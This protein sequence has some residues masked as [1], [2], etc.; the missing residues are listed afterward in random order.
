MHRLWEIMVRPLIYAIKPKHIVE[1]GSEYGHN[2]K[3]L[4]KYCDENDAKLTSID[5]KPLFDVEELKG[6]YESRFE[7]LEGLS[8]DVLPSI[9][10]YDMVLLDGDH[11]WFTVYHELKL[12]ET[13]FEDGE[14][15]LIVFH[16]ISWPYGRRDLYY[17]PDTIPKEYLNPYAQRGICPGK[18]ELVENGGLNPELYNAIEENTPR[19]GVLTGIEDF[20]KETDLDLT[21][22]TI[23]AFH[24][25]GILYP[26]NLKIDEII[27]EILSKNDIPSILEKHYLKEIITLHTYY[28]G[29]IEKYAVVIRQ[30]DEIIDGLNFEIN[31]RDQ[32]IARLI[33]EMN[34]MKK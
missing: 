6:K 10:D 32:K 11:N 30:K 25:L 8:L 13:E 3:E 22:K 20:L 14:F 5:P 15:P 4:L 27:S 17:N 7:M 23:N 19:N 16:D 9:Q 18:S 28:K 29:E 21:F 33:H 31:Q 24:G 34:L 2:T 12:I 26:K 1:V